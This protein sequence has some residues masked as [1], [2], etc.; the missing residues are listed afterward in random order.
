MISTNFRRPI[1]WN[2]YPADVP[3]SG[4]QKYIR[5]GETA[6]AL[7]CAGELDLFKEAPN[8]KE[9][10]TLR[11][12]FLHRLMVIFM[13]DVE[14]LS[15]FPEIYQKMD[16]VVKERK[17]EK[18]DK[19]KEEQ[20]LSEVVIRMSASTKARVC[21]HI[22]AVYNPAYEPLH[23][24][25][26]TIK[27]LWSPLQRDGPLKHHCDQFK[28]LFKEKQIGCVF[29]AFQIAKSEEKLEERHFGSKMPVWFIFAQLQTPLRPSPMIQ[30]FMGWYKDH[31]G[32]MKEGFLCWLVP[33]L[34]Q[35]VI[36]PMGEIPATTVAA[37]SW[38]RN[39]AG[40]KIEMD[41]YVLDKH[42]ASGRGKGLVEFA[43]HGSLVHNQA[44]FVNPLWK[45][46]YEDGKRWEE[47]VPIVGEVQPL[48]KLTEET[49]SKKPTLKKERPSESAYAFVVRTQLTTM[50]NKM[51]VYFAKNSK[52]DLVVVKGPYQTQ[53]EI[54]VLI[55]NTDWKQKHGLPYNRFMI[56]ELLAD[57]WPEGVPLGARNKIDRSRPAFFLVFESFLREDQL[58]TKI[59]SSKVWPETEVVDWSQI[60]FHFDY[61][62]NL[63]DQEWKDYVH[64]ILFRYVLG[65]SDLADRNFVRKDGRVISIDEDVENHELDLYTVLQKTKANHIHRWLTDHYEE[66][67][68][69]QWNAPLQRER[70]DIIQDKE[71]CLSL[72]RK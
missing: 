5:R 21:S 53:K 66:L 13:E 20:L 57:R 65:I 4:L 14:N 39:R 55:R 23:D 28:K 9:G 12:N 56:R 51:D 47:G 59:H 61:K 52:G 37:H 11:T 24:R 32:G 54:D 3:K 31:I 29:H 43:L 71:K 6:K 30:Q 62:A 16:S 64:A 58:R 41:D 8:Q 67:E 22:R 10:E 49:P 35:L 68:V 42:T 2:G 46:F 38:D 60:P 63:S 7:Y 72:F 69:S 25:Y 45:Q 34:H 48:K 33:L 70:L 50:A 27:A 44:S 36:L 18:R 19:E 40:E 26:P 17:E 1:T 15:L